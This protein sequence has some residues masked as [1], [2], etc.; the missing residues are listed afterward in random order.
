[1]QSIA[2]SGKRND[3]GDRDQFDDFQADLSI[4][5]L[6]SVPKTAFHINQNKR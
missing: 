2:G 5:L 3:E 1:M 4:Y 6:D